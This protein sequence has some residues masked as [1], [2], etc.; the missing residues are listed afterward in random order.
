MG[1]GELVL[2]VHGGGAIGGIAVQPGLVHAALISQS[3]LVEHH[4]FFPT[5]RRVVLGEHA[6]IAGQPVAACWVDAELL[7]AR[8]VYIS[9][10]LCFLCNRFNWLL[11]ECLTLRHRRIRGEGDIHIADPLGTG[12]AVLSLRLRCL[13]LLLARS[14]DSAG[15]G[16]LLGLCLL[17][18][19]RH[20]LQRTHAGD[21]LVLADDRTNRR[22]IGWQA[23]NQPAAVRL[24]LASDRASS[25]RKLCRGGIEVR[26]LRIHPAPTV[27]HQPLRVGGIGTGASPGVRSQAVDAGADGLDSLCDWR[28]LDKGRHSPG[29]HGRAGADC[30]HHVADNPLVYARLQFA[31]NRWEKSRVVFRPCHYAASLVF[32]MEDLMILLVCVHN[33]EAYSPSDGSEMVTK[34]ELTF[35]VMSEWN[36][37]S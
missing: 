15:C 34:P 4:A 28:L 12:Q 27:T 11:H 1:V 19:V 33:G 35:K 10:V 20:R 37:I 26:H 16:L 24:H 25:C 3:L 23:F 5:H 9:I 17:L 36:D 6:I 31:L 18:L 32:L 29:R 7:A 21:S 13:L 14:L 30:L 8:G 2:V 22:F